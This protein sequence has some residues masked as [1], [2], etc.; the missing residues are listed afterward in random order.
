[1][2]LTAEP[3]N[4][5]PRPEDQLEA[6]FPEGWPAFITA[7]QDAKRYIGPVRE[8]FGDL[9]LVL[10]DGDD[11]IVAAGWAVPVTWDG[12]PDTLPAGY[13]DSLARA[14]ANHQRGEVADTLVIMAA[15]VHPGRRGQG[16]AGELLTAFRDLAGRRGWQRVIAPV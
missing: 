14:L 5:R 15:Q 10:L 1:M 11:V 3:M 12:D 8:L 16:L 6:L 9:E 4:A 13:T 2:S 7:D